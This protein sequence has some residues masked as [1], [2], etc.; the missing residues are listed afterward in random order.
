MVMVSPA[1]ET[2]M[3]GFLRLNAC[4]RTERDDGDRR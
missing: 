3:D 4:L 1:V 2:V